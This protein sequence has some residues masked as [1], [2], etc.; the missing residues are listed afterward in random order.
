MDDYKKELADLEAAR[1]LQQ[2]QNIDDIKAVL[3][4]PAGRRFFRRMMTDAEILGV[5]FVPGQPDLSD[6]RDGI[7]NFAL[8]YFG[9]ACEAIGENI[10]KILP[11]RK[12]ED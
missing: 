3:E 1:K 7:K 5:A 8:R 4:L 9:D 12:E 2:N 11:K 10:F 6:F